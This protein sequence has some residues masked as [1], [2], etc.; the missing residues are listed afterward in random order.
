L[1]LH[2]Q[3]QQVKI[4]F[5]TGRQR[6][7]DQ[8]TKDWIN[9]HFHTD[10]QTWDAENPLSFALFMRDDEDKRHDYETKR[11]LYSR[12][13]EGRYRVLGV[14]EDRDRNVAM[15]RKLGLQTYQTTYGK[16]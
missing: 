7:F 15:F 16:Y 5:F 13:I 10:A 6:R 9:L 3:Q 1:L 2:L 14:F 12:H 8:V 11:E 4:I